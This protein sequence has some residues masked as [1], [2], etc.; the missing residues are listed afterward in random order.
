MLNDFRVFPGC[1][2]WVCH[3]THFLA[4][5]KNRY[6]KAVDKITIFIPV[7][8]QIDSEQNISDKLIGIRNWVF[9]KAVDK[10]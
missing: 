1:I 5:L 4:A 2:V 9:V 3:E 7:F 8:I 6:C 10:V